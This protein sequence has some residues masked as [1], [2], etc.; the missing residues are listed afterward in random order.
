MAST[1]SLSNAEELGGDRRLR[2]AFELLAR[3][4]VRVLSLDLFDTVVW[5][6]VPKP[7]DVFTLLGERLIATGRLPASLP[8]SAFRRLR[9]GAEERARDRQRGKG[10]G[11]EVT[12]AEIWAE[13]PAGLI[14]A[15]AD[16]LVDEELALE[17]ELLRPD[18]DVLE[19]I[20]Y[21]RQR[22]KRVVA[23]S[24]TYFTA[25][26][27]HDI[28]LSRAPLTPEHFDALI[29]S[30]DHGHGKGSGMFTRMLSQL[31]VDA[32]EVVHVGDNPE[33]DVDAAR[34][35]GLHAVLFARRPGSLRFA[36]R[37]EQAYAPQLHAGH[38]DFGLTGLRAKALAR[39]E[40][41]QLPETLR[42]F[43]H[44]G[45]GH[46]GPVFCGFAQWVVE[47][48]RAYGVERVFC[49][50]REGELLVPLVESF[51]GACEGRTGGAGE[52]RA[53]GAERLWLSR[54]VV[55]RAAIREA[56]REELDGFC[57]RRRS[58]T[59]SELC[60][61]LGITLDAS[62]RLAALPDARLN[63]GAL[64]EWT[65]DAISSDPELRATI[66]A[67]AA[68]LR[69][70]VLRSVTDALPAGERTLVLVDVGWGATIQGM[71]QRLLNDADAGVS[72]RGLYMLTNASA[73]E[74]VLDGTPVEGFLA[75]LNE[76]SYVVD[77]ISRS[78][79]VL[80]QV[81]MPDHGT[82]VAIDADGDPVLATNPASRQQ[83]A[84]RAAA[85]RGILAFQ[86]EWARYDGAV[87]GG[88][89]PLTDGAAPRLLA[90]AARAVA[91]PTLEEAQAFGRWLHEDNFGSSHAEAIAGAP[92]AEMLSHADSSLLHALTTQDLYWP[93]GL[94][95]IHDE[96]LARAMELVSMGLL[97]WRAFA[98]EADTG[99]FEVFPDFGHGPLAELKA[100]VQPRRNR[101]G[102]SYVRCWVHGD[103]IAALRIDPAEI[104]S[105]I[106]FDL[107]SLR[108]WVHGA[109][110]PETV[111][112]RGPAELGRLRAVNCDELA[113][114][115]WLSTGVDPHVV[116]DL[117]A[118]VEGTIYSVEV[119]CAFATMT[120]PPALA[121]A[122]IADQARRL[123]AR[124]PG[125]PSPSAAQLARKL[126]GRGRASVA[127]RLGRGRG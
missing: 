52:G 95:A 27:L 22:G 51:G 28:A 115:L 82:Q 33:A 38:G 7:T 71:L 53:V 127:R 113:P 90:I 6:A 122:E 57:R 46:A 74:R 107:L 45:A 126:L 62:P 30:S 123:R 121:R 87:A 104:A 20:D 49:L 21:A 114:G 18:L 29:I 48:A 77:T 50:M 102:L 26:Q 83:G 75:Q 10:A 116:L 68:E 86:R 8:G 12:L 103:G 16:E 73:I 109:A 40:S 14:D 76:P 72:V 54:Q 80:E 124:Y 5:R 66:V 92:I 110:E 112:L 99:S 100:H 119:E 79:E 78:P 105:I 64:R 43:F 85:Q 108:C 59:V 111:R 41:E 17:R 69:E 58:P 81:C 120:I 88:L 23:L 67:G 44:W 93:F 24:D 56:N 65:I 117:R 61:S 101:R 2:P 91:A 36:L 19:L 47:R 96:G 106:R 34:A 39:S 13:M 15:S 32:H 63:D 60:A 125:A 118:L 1:T 84:E 35:A 94:A 55:A 4:D 9:H 37:H 31:E 42:P 11:G 70:R 89:S 98:S 3:E 25:T 97:D